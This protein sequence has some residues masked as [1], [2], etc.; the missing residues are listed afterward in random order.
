MKSTNGTVA[1]DSGVSAPKAPHLVRGEHARERILAA[2]AE[3]FAREGFNGSS[4]ERIARAAGL[5]KPGLLHHFG[6]KLDLLRAVLDAREDEALLVAGRDTTT[7]QV[8]DTLLT[9]ARRDVADDTRTRGFAV[10]LGEA[11]ALD[12]PVADWFREH[13]AQL[14][15]EIA[16]AVRAA[17]STGSARTDIDPDAVAAEAVAVMD[18]LQIQWLLGGDSDS[19]LAR[20]EGYLMRLHDHLVEGTSPT[21]VPGTDSAP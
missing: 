11:V 1:E 5:T 6:S 14:T 21:S 3:A 9:V 12:S 15:D 4:L 18:G 19:Y 20:F 8:F 10:L 16:S 7:L 17:A 2:A 13:Y